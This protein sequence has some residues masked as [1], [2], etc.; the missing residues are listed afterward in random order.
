MKK[1]KRKFFQQQLKKLNETEKKQ[2]YK[3]AANLRK[4]SQV[5]AMKRKHSFRSRI[6]HRSNWDNE[7]NFEKKKKTPKMDIDDWALKVLEEEGIQTLRE[8]CRHREDLGEYS[9]KYYGMIEEV[10]PA[11]SLVYSEGRDVKC[12]IGP[13]F[14]MTQKSD[15]AVGDNVYFSYAKDGTA[16][17][18]SVEPRK[19]CISRPDPTKAGI[20]RV[21]A[22][23]VDKAVIV[24][25]I[26][27]PELRPSLIDRYLI[28]AQKGGVE[29]VVCINKID[30]INEYAKEKEM[31]VLKAYQEIGLK[32]VECSAASGLGL[33][34]L[35]E[36]LASARSVFVGHS[37][38]G[39]TSLL[40]RLCPCAEAQ[41]GSVH[42]GTGLGR[43]TTNNSK[44][45]HIENNIWIIDTPGIREFGLWNMNPD[46]LKWYFE[47]FD[48][49]A[50]NCRYS[51]CSHTHEPGCAVKQ[52]VEENQISRTR[53][54]S[55][56]RILET[57][58]KNSS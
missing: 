47:E 26:K 33:D 45:Y 4:A 39:K 46:D 40:N 56:L 1:S 20:E 34:K 52:A 24:A 31:E 50:E 42:N 8:T 27:R 9:E 22:A 41:T 3:R 51:D 5:D 17:L 58:S 30:L 12:I 18:H 23:N 6:D 15:L 57:I 25:A 19:T 14:S 43:H 38:T 44:L 16:V 55:Y 2:L 28:A 32:V 37:G 7:S 35:K 13:E 29:P 49:F 36:S 11:E 10:M 21:T 48:Y 53:Y 54:Q